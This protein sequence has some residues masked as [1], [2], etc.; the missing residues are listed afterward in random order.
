[1]R[2][3][4]SNEG[5]LSIEGLHRL[6]QDRQVN[7]LR[8]WIREQGLGAPSAAR[9][10]SILGDLMEA[11]VD[12]EPLVRWETG[13]LRRYRGRLYAMRPLAESPPGTLRFD[14]A[15]PAGVD[16]RRRAGANLAWSESEQGGLDPGAVC[17]RWKSVSGW[18]ASRCGRIPRGR[19]SA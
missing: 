2:R 18:V 14:P 16:A 15:E 8:W 10:E 9:F 17:A 7:V 1:M 6:P 11:R 12:A 3:D 5:R 19:A 4:F 13:E